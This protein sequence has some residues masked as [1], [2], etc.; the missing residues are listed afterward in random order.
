VVDQATLPF[1][2][3]YRGAN[4]LDSGVGRETVDATLYAGLSLWRGAE[5]WINP[6]IDQ[7]FGLSG[8]LGAAGFPSGEAYKVGKRDPYMRLQRLF[9][10]Q[11]IDLGGDSEVVAADL[12]Q[13]AGKRSADRLVITVGKI[14]VPD[15]F[16]ANTYAHD[17]RHDFLNWSILDT[18]T[19]DYAADAWGYTVGAAGEWYPGPWTVRLGLFDLSD[20]PNSA[21]L[22]QRFGQFQTDAEVERRYQ[23]G[24]QPGAIKIT[25]VPDAAT[26]GP[27]PGRR[28]ARGG[29]RNA[30]RHWRCPPIPQP[31]R[32]QPE[33]PATDLR[34]PGRVRA[35]RSGGWRRGA[36]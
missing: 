30:R 17:P 12:N 21:T 9:V 19:F 26:D 29:D 3:P 15:I 27:L 20:V 5:L 14:S 24:G 2:L 35:D 4:S 22:D 33:Y 25:A 13:L 18:G 6:E 10:R 23:L 34:R 28:S 36:L 7:G 11:T 31:R 16:D 8:T 32:R 1:R